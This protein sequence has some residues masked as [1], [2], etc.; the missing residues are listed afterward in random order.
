[1][2]FGAVLRQ[3]RVAAALTQE[4]LAERSKVSPRTIS[5]LERG[6]AKVPHADT[7]L[8]LALG[9]ELTGPARDSFELAA[10][11]RA[12][13]G[14]PAASGATGTM[15]TLPRDIDSFTGREGEVRKLAGTASARGAAGIY[16][17]DGMAGVGKTALAVH[18]AHLLRDQFPDR[19][20]FID[21]HA[22]TPGQDPVPPE[23]AL[24][25][26]LTAVGLDA[27][28]LPDDLDARA[29]LWRHKLAS[30]RVLL[31]LDNAASS[32][33]IAPLLPGGEDCL[34]LVTS[35]RHL[36]DLP[37]PA[38]PVLLDA[39]PPDQA[40]EMFVRLAPG[41]AVGPVAAVQALVRLAGYLPL[42][43]SLLARVY[44]RHPS[45]TLADLTAETSASLLTL[46]AEKHSVAAAFEVSYRYLPPGQQQFFRRLGLH[47]GSTIDAYAAA[48]LAGVPLDEAGGQLNALHGEGLLTEVG[49][50]RYGM[51]DL[52][53]RYAEDL[54]AADPAADRDQALGSL[55][56]YYQGAGA[57]ADALMARQP[58]S[59]P[60]PV[61]HTAPPVAVPTLPDRA[62]ALSWARAERVNLLACLD[63]ATL[64]GQHAR[65]VAL[66][67]AVAALLRQDG[68]WAYAITQH[69]VAVQTALHLGDRQGHANALD[70][71]GVV[72]R[73]TGKYPAAAEAQEEAL[74]IYRDLG[75]R[76]GQANA[77]NHLGTLRSLTDD[78]RPA[79]EALEAALGIC[80]DLGDRQGQA[81]T[82]NH[83]G[84]VLRLTG[85]FRGAA[86]AQEEALS[87]FRDLGNRQGQ[88]NAL[89]YL[90]AVRRR[91]GDYPGA[92]EAQQAALSIFRDLGNRQGQANALNYLGAVLQ[93]TGD[94]PGAAQAHEEALSIYRDLGNLLGEANALAE[95]GSVRRQTG[96]YRSAADAQQEA[97]SLY[98]GLGDRLGQANALYELGIVRRLTGDY[99]A[100]A[101]ML[102]ASLNICRKLGDRGS[103][104]EALDELGTLR[105]VR[106][107]LD[108][109]RACHRKALDLARE[110]HSSWDEA[111]ALA[112]LGR[113]ALAVGDTV[114]AEAGLRQ[115]REIFQRIGAAEAVSMAAELD[116]LTEAS[117]SPKLG[118]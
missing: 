93:Q 1:V 105:R 88:A 34:V 84:V 27:R 114:E 30:Q 50:H 15:R 110:I 5:D 106:G 104:A 65:V 62:A 90:G 14:G 85:N 102:E 103:E 96:D 36:G 41:A 18:V 51:H 117:R 31:V 47:P 46:A 99:P 29:G 57:I 80:R 54:A 101:R 111:R 116:A 112:G 16:A 35:R 113:C 39:L 33:Q 59:M 97:L 71:L 7:V 53:R 87:I 56:G 69:A 6:I 78:Y 98:R 48:A 61:G 19:Q 12:P 38:V 32:A 49:Y 115:A 92:A 10:R 21:L 45:W 22:H 25:G 81:D 43:V 55:M 20:L 74:R 23:A 63:Y 3:L 95:L 4:E 86:E 40:H 82:L 28:Y 72:L 100:A 67:A 64:T 94:Y 109:A 26:L 68:P 108:G 89:N 60:G 83:L 79:T 11:R 42:A 17:I 77:L 13:P 107:D 75:D 58:R 91:V 76:Q 9:L 70:D 66:T 8:R 73:L 37:G 2:R 24:A 44:A 118:S 52:I